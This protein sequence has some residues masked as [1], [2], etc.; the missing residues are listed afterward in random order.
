MGAF[1]SDLH[2]GSGMKKR[3]AQGD[4][5]VILLVFLFVAA[6]MMLASR[7]PSMIERRF[8]ARKAQQQAVHPERRVTETTVEIMLQD[9]RR[10]PQLESE[11]LIK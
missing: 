4:A 11:A 10:L 7:Y 2:G 9:E 3:R 1:W 5:G 6:L 8:E